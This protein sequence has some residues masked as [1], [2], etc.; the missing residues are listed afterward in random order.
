MYVLLVFYTEDKVRSLVV[1]HRGHVLYYVPVFLYRLTFPVRAVRDGN[2][3]R[4]HRME[5]LGLDDLPSS[6][7]EKVKGVG[8]HGAVSHIFFCQSVNVPHRVHR[9]LYENILPPCIL[10]HTWSI[11]SSVLCKFFCCTYIFSFF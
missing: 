10:Y 7:N 1:G 5:L 11:R 8:K 2:L 4:V 6:V 3:R 9:L